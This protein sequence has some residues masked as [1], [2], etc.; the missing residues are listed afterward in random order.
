M[1][2]PIDP[3]ARRKR[4]RRGQRG[5]GLYL[6]PQLFTTAN[7]LF[8]FYA[9]IQ[10][11]EGHYDR[12][13]LGIVLA[14]VGDGLDG[15]VARLSHSTSSFGREY[16]SL[17]DVVSFGVAPAL[18]AFHAGNLASLHRAG[19]VMAFLFTACAA[20]R[21][22]RF[23]VSESRYRGRFEGLPSPAAAGI[24]AS[25]QWFISFLREQGIPV[26]VPESFVALGSMALG[27]LMV[28]AVPYH[29]FKELDLRHSYRT[30]VAAVLVL[31]V[32]VLEPS[33]SLFAM[34][35]LYATSGPVEWLWRRVT[36]RPLQAGEDPLEAGDP[37]QERI[38]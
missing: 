31:T 27:L 3:Q 25:T 9:I 28:S 1:T 36:G 30:L 7:L 12:A 8:G 21:L 4:R 19:W 37:Q 20:L 22:A 16:D 18:L 17:A 2:H 26:E 15:R 24:V 10:A 38:G 35:L 5:R 33:L 13:A 32:V 11:V 23:N 34:G 29:S 6:L 14:V